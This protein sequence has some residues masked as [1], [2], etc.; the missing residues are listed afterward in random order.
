MPKQNKI[1]KHNESPALR[2]AVGYWIYNVKNDRLNL[3]EGIKETLGL[4]QCTHLAFSSFKS[5]IIGADV[6][7][8]AQTFNDWINGNTNKI[9]QA[10]IVDR[11]NNI[12]II[13]IKGR[14]RGDMRNDEIMLYGAYIDISYWAN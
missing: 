7:K 1:E 3:S 5:L 4:E 8:F 2:G 14:L 10:R 13:Q 6:P 11:H 9:I 12:R